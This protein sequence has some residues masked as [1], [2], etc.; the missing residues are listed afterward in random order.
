M[1]LLRNLI[2]C[3]SLVLVT[4]CGENREEEA[5]SRMVSAE[6]LLTIGA[7]D[8]ALAK[9][10]S[11]PARPQDARYVKLLASAY[12]CMANYTTTGLIND[13]QNLFSGGIG[14]NFISSLTTMSISQT[15]DGPTNRDYAETFLAINALLF[16]GQTSTSENPSAAFRLEDFNTTES[17]EINSFL[18]Y[19]ILTEV[20]KY[21]YHYGDT[22]NAGAK[23]GQGNHVCMMSYSAVGNIAAILGGG[24]TG[25]CTATGQTG[26]PDLKPTGGSAVN[27]NRACQAIVLFNNFY[28]IVPNLALG[29]LDGVD[30]SS[31]QTALDA[32][33]TTLLAAGG[34]T[35]TTITQV[36]SVSI[37][38]SQFAANT[39]DLEIYFANIFEPLHSL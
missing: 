28:D 21:F 26:S 13:L 7:C 1:V 38:E 36:R 29:S 33:F 39:N 34:L 22:D 8:A 17:D 14:A 19:L 20:G 37:C 3:L 6:H 16:S 9:M 5:D 35:D 15:N 24:V 32:L 23:G 10:Q 18:F 31:L 12:A 2:L 27:V 11:F 30:L 4:S 25:S